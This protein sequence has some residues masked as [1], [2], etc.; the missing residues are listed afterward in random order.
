MAVV[1]SVTALNVGWFDLV[2]RSWSLERRTSLGPSPSADA[3]SAVPTRTSDAP[4]AI[5]DRE[6]A[7]A[8]HDSRAIN[9][10]PPAAV[11]QSPRFAVEFGPFAS[12]ADAARTERQI[13]QAGHP[14][15][16]FR[17]QTGAALYAVLIEQVASARAAQEVVAALRDQAFSDPVILSDG[18]T[19][20]IRI[21]EP[22]LLRAAVQLGTSLRAKNY[23]VRVASQAGE[24]QTFVIRHGN[25]AS[26]TEAQGGSAE[27]E[28]SGLPN[29][30]VRSQ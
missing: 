29:H 27:F 28:R 19:L 20:S 6:P 8:I 10:G 3:S 24:A 21:G 1:I 30:I 4:A 16:R 14:T 2:E 26:H 22:M 17:R 11:A 25:F 13:N 5:D 9:E 23:Q 15:V 7:A 12:D 18:D